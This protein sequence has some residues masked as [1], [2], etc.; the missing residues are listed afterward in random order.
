MFNKNIYIPLIFVFVL[1]FCRIHLAYAAELEDEDLPISFKIEMLPWDKVDKIIPNKTKFTI[2]DM[3]TGKKFDVQ[4]RAGSKH[5]DVQPLTTEDTRIMKEIYNGKWSWKRRAA[6]VLIN[7]QLIAASMHGMP[8]GAGALQNGF[9]GHFC[10]HFSGSTTHSSKNPDFPHELMILKAAG[11]M[12]EYLNSISPEE[13]VEVFTEAVNQGDKTLV[14]LT[15]THFY[16]RESF[17][18]LIGEINYLDVGSLSAIHPEETSGL[19][20]VEVPAKAVF[21]TKEKGK[22]KKTISFIIRKDGLVD[23][24]QID[25]QSLYGELK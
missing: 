3:E 6:I 21:Y 17:E 2:I 23:R 24:W 16:K 9:P 25:S 4:R 10:V 14:D 7:D 22:V 1:A 15:M 13:L 11:K 20:M 8:H 18:K 5:A 12:D 19:M